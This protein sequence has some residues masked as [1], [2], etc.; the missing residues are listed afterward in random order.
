MTICVNC[1]EQIEFFTPRAPLP[2]EEDHPF[3]AEYEATGGWWVHSSGPAKFLRHC[4][5]GSTMPDC[6]AAE[7][8]L[9]GARA[10]PKQWTG[11]VAGEECI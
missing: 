10:E 5:F 9:R 1:G 4:A 3:R 8:K 7:A 2:V 11:A 6:F